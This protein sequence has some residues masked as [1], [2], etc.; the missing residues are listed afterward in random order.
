M[1]QD[2]RLPVAV[3][4]AG[5][6]GLAAACHL[7]ASGDRPL[8]LEAGDR[9]G[10]AIRQWAHVAMFSPWKL[11]TDKEAVK[12]LRADGWQHPPADRT[13]TGG[14]LVEQYLAPLAALSALRPHIRYRARVTAVSRQGFDKV[15]TAGR[16]QQPFVLRVVTESAEE[17]IAAKAVIDASGTWGLPNPAG[18]DGLP[19]IGENAAFDR[20]SYGIPDVLG[21][22]R[23]RYG[24]KRVMVVGGGHSALNALIELGALR[25]D[26]PSTSVSWI[27]RKAHIESA[28][29]GQTADALPARGA[30]GSQARAL[31]ETD[32]VRVVSP[33]RIARIDR[34]SDGSLAV[35]GDYHGEQRMLAADEMIVATGFRPDLSLLREL[36]VTIDPWLESSGKIGPLIDPNLHTCGTVR[37]HARVSLSMLKTG[38]LLSGSRAMEGPRLSCSQPATNRSARWL[39]RS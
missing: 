20:I 38:S 3:I 7:L 5:P 21:T 28:F 17:V 33:F 30:L 2:N 35:T 16:D 9:P 31:V 27:M 29:G 18:A 13:P 25:R 36:R 23:R 34:A 32:A 37:P 22:A 1:T 10:H 19:A 15:R 11:N 6:I 14:D 24:G 12:L 39:P 8:I 4:G 26:L